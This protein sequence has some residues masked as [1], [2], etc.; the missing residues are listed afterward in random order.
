MEENSI[1]EERENLMVPPA[2]EGLPT[3][4]RAHFLKPIYNPTNQLLPKHPSI[5]LPLNTKTK[6]LKERVVFK[7]R[8]KPHKSWSI[9]V[10]NLQKTHELSWKRAGIYDA[11]RCSTYEIKEDNELIIGL[12][13]KWCPDTNT[14]VFPWGEASITLEDVMILGG[15]SVFGFSVLENSCNIADDH[16]IVKKLNDACA[17]IK[18]DTNVSNVS[19]LEWMN[20]FKGYG[21]EMENV[22]LIVLWLSSLARGTR[23]ALAPAVLALIYRDL[24]LLKKKILSLNCEDGQG[25]GSKLVLWAPFQLIQVWAWERFRTLGPKPEPLV[26]GEPRL[27]RWHGVNGV[28][29]RRLRVEI[30]S[31]GG[32]F[33]WRPYALYVRNWE[34]PKFYC[35][36][37]MWVLVDS[38]VDEELLSFGVCLRVCE[39]V[40]VNCV[41]QYLPH[42]VAMQFGMDQDIPISIP[43]LNADVELAWSSYDKPLHGLKFYIPP[44]LLEGDITIQYS[45]WWKTLD[46]LPVEKPIQRNRKTKVK[47]LSQILQGSKEG[48]CKEAPLPSSSP[49][50]KAVELDCL[51]NSREMPNEKLPSSVKSK[52]VQDIVIDL[53]LGLD[54]NRKN[55][56]NAIEQDREKEVNESNAIEED[57]EKE[58][59]ESNAIEEDREKEV[60][61]SNAIEEDR[62][63]EVN[64]LNA[65]EEERQKELY[66]SDGNLGVDSKYS[67]STQSQNEIPVG[68]SSQCNVEMYVDFAGS[69]SNRP[70]GKSTSCEHR[71]YSEG[72]CS[73]NEKLIEDKGTFSGARSLIKTETTPL[74][75]AIA[76]D[77][78]QTVA[79]VVDIEQMKPSPDDIVNV[80]DEEMDTVAVDDDIKQMKT[81]P[82]VIVIVGDEEMDDYLKSFEAKS[83]EID[84]R[85]NRIEKIV[86]SL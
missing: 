14:F 29:N 59:N 15:F 56:S 37:E 74:C 32:E 52:G 57:R 58:V 3:F 81:S 23:I 68:S 53:L 54:D 31:A 45:N 13:E 84:A 8:L 39:L 82:D 44:R 70:C 6:K 20:Y 60:N 16:N 66:Q 47:K 11:I 10:E 73:P 30:E 76:E 25:D 21:G 79:V 27:A 71:E 48:N 83:L 50:T 62:E 77:V 72:A 2:N 80:S 78:H 38:E 35:D 46:S 36:E 41:K 7:G 51:G 61:E 9:W 64:E 19:H 12:V 24:S 18:K 49:C 26:H 34:F 42:R 4:R 17:K 43:R 67:E 85:L 75:G 22:A 33:L 5:C 65:I 55:E 1:V 86:S 28:R 63:K 40:G 69:S